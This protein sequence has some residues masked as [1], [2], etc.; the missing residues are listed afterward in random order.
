M[1]WQEDIETMSRADLAQIQLEGLQ[2]T[3]TRVSRNVPLYRTRFAELD[4]NPDEI[5]SSADIV[6]LP[7]TSR[8]DI[9]EHYPYGLFAVPLRDVV[10]LHASTGV[11]GASMVC[12]YTSTDIHTWSNLA[13]RVMTAAGLSKD[14]LLQVALDYG[15]RTGGLGLHYGAELLGASVIP[16][17][18]GHS[19]RQI[20]ILQDYRTTALACTPS[21]AL[22]LADLMDDSGISTNDLHLRVGL[23][24]GERWTENMRAEIETRLGIVATDHYVVSEVMGP[25]IA[26]ECNHKQGLHVNEDHFLVEI[27]DPVSS[28]PV[29]DGQ[30]GEIVITT[31]TKQAFPMVRFRTG[32]LS[33]IV[34]GP[35]CPCGRTFRRLARLEGR[36]D[37]MLVIRGVGIFPFQVGEVLESIH[38]PAPYHH[39][40][41]ETGP[42]RLDKVT[43][44]LE[45]TGAFLMDSM[46]EAQEM[47]DKLRKA[48]AARLGVTFEVLL[49]GRTSL[50]RAKPEEKYRVVDKRWS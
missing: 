13:A 15:M 36:C 19:E 34:T 26:G 33:R 50:E 6:R 17:S 43:V 21:Y 47:L 27:I 10:R 31:L 41:I 18:G 25:G 44:H 3:M 22:R 20:K 40:V 35:A 24:G 16:A 2:S 42:D 48:F 1:Y 28:E 7:F 9:I 30:T 49:V 14:D 37:D 38:S 8:S 39:I 32:D 29:P 4:I 46:R 11:G 5:L 23:F 12:G 45:A